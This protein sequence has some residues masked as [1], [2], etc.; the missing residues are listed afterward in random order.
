M[1]REYKKY[2]FRESGQGVGM[3]W[4]Y[5]YIYRIEKIRCLTYCGNI[6]PLS[7]QANSACKEAIEQ[8]ISDH[9]GNNRLNTED[10]VKEVMGKFG[11]ER[12]Q[13]ILANTIRHKD[14]DGR[15]SQDNKAWA[16]TDRKSVV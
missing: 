6:R 10:A 7:Y 4:Y 9:Y 14:S 8:A 16:K 5:Y 2:I 1:L 3:R 12:V 11:A 13:F 15:I